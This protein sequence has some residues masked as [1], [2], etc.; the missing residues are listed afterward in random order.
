MQYTIVEACHKLL[1]VHSLGL[2]HP[3]LP[4]A[5]L[6]PTPAQAAFLARALEYCK[7]PHIVVVDSLGRVD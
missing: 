5:V 4:L 7:A 3:H 1:F 2:R 6:V